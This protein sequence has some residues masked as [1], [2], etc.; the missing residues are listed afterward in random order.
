MPTFFLEHVRK[1]SDLFMQLQENVIE[2]NLHYW[3]EPMDKAYLKD[4]AEIQLQVA[5]EY[6][7]KY[8]LEKIACYRHV[9]YNRAD[10]YISQVL[11]ALVCTHK[12]SPR[13]TPSQTAAPT[14]TRCRRVT[15]RPRPGLGTSGR[16]SRA[17]RSGG[18]TGAPAAAPLAT[19]PQVC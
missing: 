4:L 6:I 5:E 11:A 3:R 13:S 15:A 8:R 16:G 1:A 2:N 17:G 12:P 19:L 14:L 7:K 9:V 18:G 10:P